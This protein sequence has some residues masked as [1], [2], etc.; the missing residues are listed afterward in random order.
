MSNLFVRIDEDFWK[1]LEVNSAFLAV[2]S[3]IFNGAKINDFGKE[4]FCDRIN[5]V[6]KSRINSNVFWLEL[7]CNED[8]KRI[9]VELDKEKYIGKLLC[10]G[11]LFIDNERIKNKGTKFVLHL[12]KAGEIVLDEI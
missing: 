2:V 12:R 11:S 8:K 7:S 6:Q 3:D 4:F 1:L 5:Y 10:K 9:V